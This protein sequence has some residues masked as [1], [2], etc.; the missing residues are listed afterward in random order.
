MNN[1]TPSSPQHQHGVKVGPTLLG[2]LTIPANIAPGSVAEKAYGR[3]I[4]YRYKYGIIGLIA[5]LVIQIAGVVLL[6]AG[7][8][9]PEPWSIELGVLGIKV[10]AAYPGL[11][12]MALGPVWAWITKFDVSTD[13]SDH[14]PPP[15]APPPTK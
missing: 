10:S 12:L 4:D 7:F 15:P 8:R 14:N 9:T 6:V 3:G 2:P 11:L 13:C 1:N 5:G